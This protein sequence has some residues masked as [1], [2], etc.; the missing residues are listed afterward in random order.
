[1][2]MSRKAFMGCDTLA[3]TVAT[4]ATWCMDST[5]ASG[6]AVIRGLYV[7]TD[8]DT[9]IK[10]LR[11]SSSPALAAG[12]RLCIDW[13]STDLPTWSY[14]AGVAAPGNITHTF[15]SHSI[16]AKR[17]YDLLNGG[18]FTL[19][20]NVFWLLQTALIAANVTVTIFWSEFDN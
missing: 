16:G 2:G 20:N 14:K 19:A 11:A 10:L 5:T 18:A 12:T 7:S 9:S 15:G 6:H 4:P 3:A 13:V 1:M 8:T 17:V